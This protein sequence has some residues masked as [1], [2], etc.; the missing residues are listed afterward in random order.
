VP[1]GSK[2]GFV[3]KQMPADADRDAQQAEVVACYRTLIR[4]LLDL[5]DNLAATA[6]GNQVVP[7]PDTVRHDGDD[8]YLVVAADKGTA[9]FSDLANAI[10]ADYGFWLGD[11]F[12]SGGSAGYDHKAMGITARGA[13]E[14]VKRHFRDIGVNCQ[15]SDFT[16]VGIGDMSGD[17]FGNGMLL[18]RHIRLVAAFDHRH[19]FVDP[20]PDAVSSYTERRRLFDLPRSSWADYD[21]SLISAGGGVWPRTAKSIPVSAQLA[22]ALGIEQRPCAP[23]EL[24]RAILRA[25]V[26]L[27]WNGG[28]GTYV[29]AASE[30]HADV[31][32]RSNDAVRVDGRELRATIVGEGGNLGFTQLGRR[33]FALAGGHINTDAIDNSAG[34]D[35][36]DHEVNIKILLDV[37]A[38]AG[39]F[40]PAERGPLLAG[41][42]DEIAAL[43]LRDNYAQ[44]LL[45]GCSQASA[46]QTLHVDAAYIDALEKAGHLDR[47][48]EHLPDTEEIAARRAAGLGLTRPEIAV[49]LAYAKINTAHEIV[50]SDLA[51]DIFAHEALVEYFPTPLRERF[52]ADIAVHPLLAEIIATQLANQLVNYSGAT[53]VATLAGETSAATADIVRAHTATRHVFDV[54][55]VW[56][57]IEALDDV[58]DASVQTAMLLALRQLLEHGTRWFLANRRQPLDVPETVAQFSSR[59]TDLL[60]ELPGWLRGQAAH[61][62]AARVDELT[63]A[64]VPTRL[65][66]RLA[67]FTEG[68]AALSVVDVARR[69]GTDVDD[70][71]DVHF[72][73]GDAL[74]LDALD[75]AVA[76]LPADSRWHALARTGAR[77]DLLLAHAELTTEVL[78]STPAGIGAEK[79]I[80]S[81]Q[82]AN[83]AAV[84]RAAAMLDDVATG[85]GPDLAALSV[86]LREIRAL[87]RTA[88]LPGR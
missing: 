49:L 45:L 17:V 54:D 84:D 37:A 40:D 65:A 69:V 68:L 47:S 64:R 70:V 72:T 23:T 9:T 14:S 41:M 48:L 3:V 73:L 8:P 25:P 28:I 87:V 53:F 35:T 55:A 59:I 52:A 30:T 5:T 29:K 2:G 12:A 82:Q 18:S 61:R 86:A 22:A 51:D 42:T 57:D 46:P 56:H 20:T 44:N 21:P 85:D 32:D 83:A 10:A 33:E 78:L 27:L 31:G 81:W 62:F 60:D 67:A 19:I 71:A 79:R 63:A 16:C 66:H 43:V 77:D 34:V 36:S 15:T 1:V 13:W 88:S 6:D 75:A 26:D 7:P 80:S 74:R 11:A 4:G 76:A 50:A 39:R 24:I 58:V 38:R